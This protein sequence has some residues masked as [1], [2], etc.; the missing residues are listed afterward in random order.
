MPLV[1]SV[2]DRIVAMDQGRVI[3]DGRPDDVLHDPGVVA[4]YL[5][6]DRAGHRPR[7]GLRT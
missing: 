2:A 1:R 4:S 5:G 6:T 3:A 7:P